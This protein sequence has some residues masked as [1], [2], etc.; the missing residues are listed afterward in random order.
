VGFVFFSDVAEVGQTGREKLGKG[1]DLL[2]DSGVS[3]KG[4]AHF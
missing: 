3:W 4:S 1:G 2:V